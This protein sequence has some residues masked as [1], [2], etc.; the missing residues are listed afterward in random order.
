MSLETDIVTSHTHDSFGYYHLGRFYQELLRFDHDTLVYKRRKRI[1]LSSV[2]AIRSYPHFLHDDVLTALKSTTPRLAIYMNDG[3]AVH[4][5]GPIKRECTLC[6]SKKPGS[7]LSED[8]VEL[9]HEFNSRGVK[10]WQGPR[11]EKVFF[12]TL[13]ILQ[14]IGLLLGVAISHWFYLDRPVEVLFITI[15]LSMLGGS[16]IACIL[17]P[18]VVRRGR[19]RY[20][21]TQNGDPGLNF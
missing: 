19:L 1:P 15:V 16:T 7:G 9:V 6:R 14:L 12:I 5:R 18:F 10:E 3:S 2:Q 17:T 20:I 4:I 13:T 21:H 8:Y 11:E